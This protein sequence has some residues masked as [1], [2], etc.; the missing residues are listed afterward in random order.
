MDCVILALPDLHHVEVSHLVNQ[1]VTG[2]EP[3]LSDYK[4]PILPLNYTGMYYCAE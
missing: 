3:V 4:T 1:P 2:V